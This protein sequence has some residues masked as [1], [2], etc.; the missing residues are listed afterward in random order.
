[1]QFKNEFAAIWYINQYHPTNMLKFFKQGRTPHGRQ[2]PQ[3]W[4]RK[5]HGS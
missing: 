1:M 3:P 5:H 4:W 2:P